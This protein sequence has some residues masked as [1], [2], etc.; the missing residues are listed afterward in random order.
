MGKWRGLCLGPPEEHSAPARLLSLDIIYLEDLVGR[1]Q[2]SSRSYPQIKTKPAS[3][4]GQIFK[5]SLKRDVSSEV[6]Q[7]VPL[8]PP[9]QVRKPA[10]FTTC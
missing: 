2:F 3:F 6:E 5:L 8:S 10:G 1:H 4:S 7:S 9:G